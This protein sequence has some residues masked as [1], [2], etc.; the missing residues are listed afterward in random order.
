LSA[1]ISSSDAL[2]APLHNQRHSSEEFPGLTTTPRSEWPKVAVQEG[3]RAIDA[4]KPGSQVHNRML[5]YLVRRLDESE[6]QMSQFHPRWRANELKNQAWVDLRKYDKLVKEANLAG[7]PPRAVDIVI[8]Y[9]FA[10][11]STISTYLLQ[12]FAGRRPYLQ[13]DTYG[14]EV[15]NARK[16]EIILQYQLDHN[17]IVKE[18]WKWFNDAGLYG[19][20]ILVNQWRVKKAMRTQ[21]ALRP[22]LDM[23]TGQLGSE[24]F[25]E[26]I[27]QTIFEGNIIRAQDPFMF[28]PDPRVPM[29]EA[30]ERGEYIFWRT[31]QGKHVLKRAEN[32]GLLNYI[33]A[34]PETVGNQTSGSLNSA[35]TLLSGDDPHAGGPMVWQEV[36]GQANYQVDTCSI[37]IIPRELGLGESDRVEKWIFTVLNRA[38]IVQAEAQLSDHDM[39]PVVIIEPFGMGYSFGSAGMA[40]YIGPIQDSMS[41]FLNSHMENVR[42]S[43]NNQLIVD[44]NVVE[45]QDVRRPGPGKLIRLKNT[46][47]N[48]DVRTAVAQL[49][50]QDVTRGHIASMETFFEIGQRISAVSENLLGL[51]DSGG[52]KT[53]TEVRTASEAAASR[54]ASLA[55]VISAQGV[56][57]L[58]NQMSQNTQQWMSEE[59]YVR[60]VGEDGSKYPLKITPDGI[61]GDFHYPVHDGTLPLDR[62]ALLDIWKQIFEGALQDPELRQTYSVPK[63]FEFIAELGGAKN[64]RS[65]RLQPMG[66]EQMQQQQQEGNLA[67]IPGG[68]GPSGLV[69]ATLPQP[70]NRLAEGLQ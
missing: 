22:V 29:S 33:D 9:S 43:I 64:I 63:L 10:T 31:Y 51:Q 59:F 38:Q 67:P 18:W 56:T 46:A 62:V 5:N 44:P 30:A 55:R 58:T 25:K 20:G 17:R 1:P 2:A 15:E 37:E 42:T 48:R 35:R 53:A 47:L 4:L 54:L 16:M 52:R 26:Q 40:D 70:G 41:W 3:S 66:P 50:V 7:K 57:A 36:M 24:P 11:L 60:V 61:T 34:A 49:P 32:N 45:M 28:F 19:V 21:T 8:P 23:R 68:Q 65:F 69:N 6:R 39:H 14:M 27:E 13:V 12:V